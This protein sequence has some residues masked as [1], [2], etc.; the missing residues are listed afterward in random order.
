MRRRGFTLIELL[1]VIAIIAVLIALLLPAVQAA[2]EAARRAQCIN[3]MKQ[4]ALACHNYATQV[5]SFPPGGINDNGW[6]GPAWNG[7]VMLLPQIEMGALYNAI[8][9]GRHNGQPENYATVS[10][11]VISAYLCPSDRSDAPINNMWWAQSNDWGTAVRLAGTNYTLSSGDMK[12][13]GIFDIF[14]SEVGGPQWGCKNTFKG[15]FGECSLGAVRSLRDCTDGS[16]N[17][18]L[19]GENSPNQ[20]GALAWTNADGSFGITTIPMN[21]MMKLDDGDKDTNGDVCKRSGA[22]LGARNHQHCRYN[23]TYNWGFRSLHPGGANFAMGD[24]S[25]RFVKQSINPLTY[26]ALGTIARGEVISSDAY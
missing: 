21:W 14:S 16:S 5:G 10:V 8:N 6:G 25:V 7:H 22:V 9:I 19:A 23:Q 13:N 12:T 2:R 11:V 20:N 26:Q 24:G 17:T 18:F 3:N 4:I 15:F 1:V